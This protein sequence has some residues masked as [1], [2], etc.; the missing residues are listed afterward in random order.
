MSIEKTMDKY[1]TEK[2]TARDFEFFNMKGKQGAE[3]QTY[4]VKYDGKFVGWIGWQG[5]GWGYRPAKKGADYQKDPGQWSNESFSTKL[6]AAKQ[7]TK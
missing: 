3:P 7:I 5:D 1:L 2:A 6:Q 4:E